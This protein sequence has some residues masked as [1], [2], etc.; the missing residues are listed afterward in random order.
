MRETPRVWR[1]FDSAERKSL[2]ANVR[3]KGILLETGKATAFGRD[4]PSFKL[5]IRSTRV[6]APIPLEFSG[7]SRDEHCGTSFRF[8]K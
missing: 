6:V 1:R 4:E 5:L 8:D 7:P 3:V 2:K